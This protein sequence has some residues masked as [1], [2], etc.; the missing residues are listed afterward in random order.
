MPPPSP[1]SRFSFDD[2]RSKNDVARVRRAY[3]FRK[4]ARKRAQQRWS[5]LLTRIERRVK[6]SDFGAFKKHANTKYKSQFIALFTSPLVCVGP[7]EG[8]PCPL[9]FGVD[10]ASMSAASELA[11]LHLDHEQ[12]VAITCDMWNAA[13]GATWDDGIDRDL[14]CHTCSLVCAA[15]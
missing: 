2:W 14:L 13:R 12:D 3:A 7:R 15:T 8:V 6:L 10:P 1:P 4:I 5:A 9:A 11:H